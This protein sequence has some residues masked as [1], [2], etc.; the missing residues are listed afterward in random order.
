MAISPAGHRCYGQ[1]H[2]LAEL[3]GCRAPGAAADQLRLVQ[4]AHGAMALQQ[5]RDLRQ[6]HRSLEV[7]AQVD[8]YRK[9]I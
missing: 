2:G 6:K 8:I 5:V 4:A 1:P 7:E 9:G 3:V